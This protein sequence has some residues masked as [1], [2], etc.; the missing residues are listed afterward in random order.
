MLWGCITPTSQHMTI[1]TSVSARGTSLPAVFPRCRPGVAFLRRFSKRS[2]G[3]V[4]LPPSPCKKARQ[5]QPKNHAEVEAD[6]EVPELGYF[7]DEAAV[8][9]LPCSQAESLPTLLPKHLVS[10]SLADK[11]GKERRV[12]FNLEHSVK[13]FDDAVALDVS[14]EFE[15]QMFCPRPPQLPRKGCQSAPFKRHLQPSGFCSLI[16]NA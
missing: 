7:S 3:L 9:M 1:S 5:K 2:T 6:R 15:N 13:Y 4:P 12:S 14:S 11:P 10:G 8:T 16:P